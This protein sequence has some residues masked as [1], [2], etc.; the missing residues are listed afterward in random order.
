MEEQKTV[1]NA[2]SGVADPGNMTTRQST[3][4]IPSKIIQYGPP[5]LGV[6]AATRQALE[7]EI[8]T[9]REHFD[10]CV[11]SFEKNGQYIEKLLKTN[12]ELIEVKLSGQIQT[13]EK[14]VDILMYER[15]KTSERRWSMKVLVISSVLCLVAGAAITLAIEKWLLPLMR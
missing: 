8:K 13:L 7:T 5:Y 2:D 10:S 11:S 12:L 4:P 9:I 6:E 14:D 15:A 3:G 1:E